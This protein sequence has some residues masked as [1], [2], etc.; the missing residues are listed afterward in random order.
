MSEF[1]A[2]AEA[3]RIPHQLEVLPRGGT[4]AGGMQRARGGARVI[5]LSIPLRYVHSV[6]ECA[7]RGDIQAAIDLLAAY[8]D[9]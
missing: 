4:D 6:N 7:H 5:T 9:R 8:L 3:K 1:R 2:L